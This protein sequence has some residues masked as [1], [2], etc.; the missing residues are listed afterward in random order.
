MSAQRASTQLAMKIAKNLPSLENSSEF[1]LWE[2]A[3]TNICQDIKAS[4]GNLTVHDKVFVNHNQAN[5]APP[6]DDAQSHRFAMMLMKMS[7]GDVARV[8][9]NFS[10]P[11]QA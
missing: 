7:A 11:I 5:A 9:D 10:A 4:Q 2:E 6:N 8:R 1:A 3:I